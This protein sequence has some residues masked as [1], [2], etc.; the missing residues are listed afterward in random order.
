MGLCSPGARDV[1]V[2]FA[3]NVCLGFSFGGGA[4]APGNSS[5]KGKYMVSYSVSKWDVACAR[6]G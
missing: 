3:Y 6:L 5:V 2:P 4:A 1:A